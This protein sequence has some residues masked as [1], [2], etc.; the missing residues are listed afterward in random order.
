MGKSYDSL[1]GVESDA[2]GD[3]GASPDGLGGSPDGL[4]DTDFD[5]SDTPDDMADP[6]EGPQRDFNIPRGG[7]AYEPGAMPAYPYGATAGP[8]DFVEPED[9]SSASAT[10]SAGLTVLFVAAAAGIG[11]AVRGG[12]GAA[13]GVLLAGSVANVYRAQKWWKSEDPSEKHEAVVSAVFAA[14]GLLAGG[15]VG[16]KAAGG[17]K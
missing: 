15:Y 6:D 4:G 14:G 10:R 8:I 17:G 12:L 7:N 9:V 5:E 3:L 1:F 13:S 2:F 16:Y 11:Y